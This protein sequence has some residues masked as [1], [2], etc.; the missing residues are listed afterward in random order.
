MVKEKVCSC[1]IWIFQCIKIIRTV[2]LCLHT[3]DIHLSNPGNNLSVGALQLYAK[4][5]GK[6]TNQTKNL[7][8]KCSP[9]KHGQE[10]EWLC[11]V[12]P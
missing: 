10:A 1:R 12:R 2:L 11:E 3:A 6:K 7:Q 8:C 5:K 4:E 9:R